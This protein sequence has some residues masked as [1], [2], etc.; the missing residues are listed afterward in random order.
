[1]MAKTP[2]LEAIVA[3]PK[4]MLHD[5]LGR[6]LAA[7]HR[8]RTGRRPATTPANTDA[9]DLA[10]WM[11]RGASRLNLELY[12]ETFAH[13]VG[14]MQTADA[15]ERVAYECAEDLANDGVVYAEV[16]FAPELHVEKGLSLD[17]VVDAVQAGFARGMAD[18]DIRIGTLITAMRHA[19][20]SL[21]IAE[22]AVRHR[23]NQVVGFDI[24]GAEAGNPPTR[25]PRRLPYCGAER[26]GHGMRIIDDIDTSGDEPQL[27]RLA[28]FVHRRIPLELC[29]SSNVHTGAAASIAEHPIGLLAELRYRCTQIFADIEERQRQL[30]L[31]W[32]TSPEELD[33]Q[34]AEV[35]RA[36][37]TTYGY[38]SRSRSPW[39]SFACKV[40]DHQI[41]PADIAK[42]ISWGQEMLAEPVELLDGVQDTVAALAENYRLIIMTKGDIYHQQEKIKTSG[43]LE[44]V[45]GYSVMAFKDEDTYRK[46]LDTHVVETDGFVMVGNSVPSDVLP[47]VNIGGHGVHI[48]YHITWEHE[49]HDEASPDTHGYH[50]LNDITELPDQQDYEQQHEQRHELAIAQQWPVGVTTVSASLAI[51]AA[52]GIRVFATGG[53]GG[54]H[55]GAGETGDISADLPALSR[56]PVLPTTSRPFTCG[57]SGLPVP[58]RVDTPAEA[59]AVLAAGPGVGYNGGVLVANP[60]PAEAALD[61]DE[62]W[63]VIDDAQA[64]AN[65]AGPGR[66]RGDT[67]HPWATPGIAQPP[68]CLRPH[69]PS[70]ACRGTCGSPPPLPGEV[71]QI[72]R[73]SIPT[74][75]SSIAAP[76]ATTPR[77]HCVPSQPPRERT[78]CGRRTRHRGQLREQKAVPWRK[79][80]RRG[81]MANVTITIVDHPIVAERLTRVRDKTTKR[82]GFRRNL[83]E[84]SALLVYESLRNQ[85]VTIK[86]IDTPMGP[87]E[88]VQVA[89]PPLIV[90]VL[91]A[92]LGMLD[93]ALELVPNARVGFVGAKRNEET[94]LPDAYVNTVPDDL[95][96][97]A[98]MVLDP[99]LATGGSLIHTCALLQESNAG[100]IDVVCVLASPEG[101][102][103]FTA[104]GFNADVTTAAID[105][106][107]NEVA[108]IIP[109][110]GDAGDRQFGLA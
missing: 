30:L 2:T 89:E 24:A 107:L 85:A 61:A 78:R 39:W 79:R 35:K 28:A 93:A 45:D 43:L 38:G 91:R 102:D 64:A 4:V 29:P 59:A 67:I 9:D 57:T 21:E 77:A 3:A 23:D 31:P 6:R 108:Y 104:A 34:L 84:L 1:M 98:V 36:N 42:L 62:V 7:R 81:T 65:E 26:L 52:A 83:K 73:R 105:D 87:A 58:H 75:R 97:K 46:E 51:S 12:L 82:A 40:S 110:L 68:Q 72:P 95:E 49:V 32:A 109:G 44:L 69:L 103:A 74:R 17:Q 37:L 8:D 53:I 10:T 106:C 33:Q 25:P 100:K 11:V 80:Y 14:V 50:Q 22:L 66:R 55:R 70:P 86:Q 101:L 99:M 5:H 54:A 48:P 63:A 60:L 15:L 76:T 13:T 92:G 27:G 20:R 16:R 71:A 96:G 90:P 88:G 18:Y 56:Y 41:D 47:V 19:A 94:L